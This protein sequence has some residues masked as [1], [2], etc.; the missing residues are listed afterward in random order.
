MSR[1][2]VKQQ[3]NVREIAPDNEK[4]REQRYSFNFFVISFNFGGGV[5][6]RDSKEKEGVRAELDFLGELAIFTEDNK[7]ES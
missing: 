3:V 5:D 7:Y 1:V 4:R 6:E 2:G